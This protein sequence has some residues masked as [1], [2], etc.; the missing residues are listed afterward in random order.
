ME[1]WSQTTQLILMTHSGVC[2]N[3]TSAIYFFKTSLI[4]F[5]ASETHG[6]SANW[7]ALYG[8]FPPLAR[9]LNWIVAPRKKY[10]FLGVFKGK[11]LQG[12]AFPYARGCHESGFR[13]CYCSQVTGI[14][15]QCAGRG[16]AETVTKYSVTPPN[17]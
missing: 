2:W 14:A 9:G 3:Q 1:I 17:I 16:I 12:N 10:M 8:G 7:H 11:F 6:K 13:S 5:G 4:K 15:I